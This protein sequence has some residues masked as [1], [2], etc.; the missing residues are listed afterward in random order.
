MSQCT[1]SPS[2]ETYQDTHVAVMEVGKH[3]CTWAPVSGHLTLALKIYIGA[4]TY[5]GLVRREC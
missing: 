4:Y 5:I 1:Y 3:L 2:T